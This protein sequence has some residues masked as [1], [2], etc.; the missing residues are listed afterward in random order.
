MT[1]N[2]VLP[3]C[4]ILMVSPFVQYFLLSAP[5]LTQSMSCSTP[6]DYVRYIHA[7]IFQTDAIMYIIVL[8]YVL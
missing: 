3:T 1:L 8:R 2:Q 6:N 5:R 7:F 4:M